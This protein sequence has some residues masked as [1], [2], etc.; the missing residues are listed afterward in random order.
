MQLERNNNNKNFVNSSVKLNI[1]HTDDYEKVNLQ[2][3]QRRLSETEI[4]EELEE[5]SCVNN[6]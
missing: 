4:K 2:Q 3:Y 1:I 6:V 5:D